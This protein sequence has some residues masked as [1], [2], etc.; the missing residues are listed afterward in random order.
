MTRVRRARLAD[1]FDLA[2]IEVA[3]WR[4]AYQ[5]LLPRPY[6]R[7][8]TIDRCRARWVERLAGADHGGDDHWALEHDGALVGYCT[9]GPA[10]ADPDFAAEVFT[11]Y[12]HPDR[13]C[14][15]LGGVLFER[16]VESLSERR[17]GWLY[18]WVLAENARARRF[19]VRQGMV[20]DGQRRL[21]RTGGR[22]VHVVRYARPLNPLLP[23]PA[24]DLHGSD[25]AET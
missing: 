16:T 3:S 7:R 9:A 17:F 24:A 25:A 18:V 5:V 19:Y 12:L 10:R 22:R 14:R 11:L 21:D 1:A 23:W 2:R 15:G 20:A 4:A 13:W 8:I 6:L